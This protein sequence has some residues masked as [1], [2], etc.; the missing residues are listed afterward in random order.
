MLTR[1]VLMREHHRAGST[2]TLTASDLGSSQRGNITQ[3][4]S[5]LHVGGGISQLLPL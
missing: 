2:A 5:E 4:L 3:V 1:V